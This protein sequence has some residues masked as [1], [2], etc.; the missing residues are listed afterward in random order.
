MPTTLEVTGY[1]LEE[2]KTANPKAYERLAERWRELIYQDSG[3]WTDE[4]MESLKAVI[5]ACGGTLTDWNI[6][7][8]SGWCTVRVEDDYEYVNASGE[9]SARKGPAWFRR[10]VLKPH[11]YLKPNGRADFPGNCAFTGYCADDAFLERAYERIRKGDTLTEALESLAG[12]ASKMLADDL[13]Q[14][15]STES[16]EANWGDNLYTLEG[17]RIHK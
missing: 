2:L 13:E 15:A 11:G 3:L 14:T 4:T 7:P 5:T 17:H 9:H 1:T 12:L 6:G 10:E 16:M 8:D